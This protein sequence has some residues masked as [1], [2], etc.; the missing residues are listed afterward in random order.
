[1][2]DVD[3][4]DGAAPVVA[5]PTREDYAAILAALD[6]CSRAL[7]GPAEPVALS[8]PLRDADGAVEGGLWGSTMFGWLFVQ[9]L[10]VPERLRGRGLGRLLVRRAEAEARRRGCIGAYVQS[11]SFQAGGFYERLGYRSFGVLRD[12][13]PG[14]A[15]LHFSRRLDEGVDLA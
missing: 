3:V 9:L 5:V 4:L 8:I 11:F 2:R 1:M 6:A 14:F 10:V 12:Y 15:L 7:I 13:P